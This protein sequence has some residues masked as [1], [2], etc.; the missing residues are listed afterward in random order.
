MHL[1]SSAPGIARRE[2]AL[3][4]SAVAEWAETAAAAAGIRREDLACA[5]AGDFNLAASEPAN[6]A[7]W[8]P[9]LER[10][11]APALCG[12]EST[13]VWEFNVGGEDVGQEYDNIFVWPNDWLH[14][15]PAGRVATLTAIAPLRE[16]MHHADAAIRAAADARQAAAPPDAAAAAARV[17]LAA[18]RGLRKELQPQVFR[19]LSD[20][21]PV[22]VELRLAE[23]APAA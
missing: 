17:A 21:K 3:L 20:H 16:E 10:G 8:A 4:G 13:N 23:E 15:P 12:G 11:F 14:A 5:I 19:Q 7:A 22:T 2:A 9:L 6:A 1:K 18:R